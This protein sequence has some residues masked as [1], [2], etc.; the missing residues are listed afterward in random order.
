MSIPSCT[1]ELVTH[2]AITPFVQISGTAFDMRYLNRML[3]YWKHHL[4]KLDL[5]IR[6]QNILQFSNLV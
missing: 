5:T 3:G 2:K 6:R 1:L 4:S